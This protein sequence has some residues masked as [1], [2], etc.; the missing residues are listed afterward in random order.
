L[1][2]Q[3]EVHEH[4]RVSVV[5]PSYNMARYLEET[6]E[7]VLSQDYPHIEYI[8]MDGGSTD[9]TLELLRKYDGRLRYE[10]GR[11]RG[12]ADAINHGFEQ[13]SGRIFAYLNADDTY[14]P[15]A[16]GKAVR[17]L[18]ANAG[19]GG[20]YGEGYHVD[21][22][23][24]ILGRY[25]TKDFDLELLREECFICQPAA[26]VRREAFAEA[27]MMRL[28]LHFALDYDLWIR[29]GKRRPLL[30]I[31]D[32]LAKSR[33]Y[34]EN[35]T[36]RARSQ[37]FREAIRVVHSHFG[38]VSYGHMHGYASALLHRQD[39][40]FE[41]VPAT[42]ATYTLALLLGLWKN[43]PH[44]GRFWREAVVHSRLGQRQQ[45]QELH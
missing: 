16:V 6:I 11:D 20:V 12:Q 21:Q 1:S 32:Y 15:G 45:S 5:T 29:I 22:Q 42:R 28:D 8:V 30:K 27:G 26:F 7:S 10:S 39:G 34:R 31:D 38:Y 24:K 4:P 9:G 14:L 18:T 2:A 3:V 13:S 43:F 44:T 37:V 40:F 25:P 19:C 33:M 41:P 23:G 35:K 36:L 17:H